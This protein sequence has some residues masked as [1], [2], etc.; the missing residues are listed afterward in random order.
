MPKLPKIAQKYPI[1]K[2]TQ[3]SNKFGGGGIITAMKTFA[4]LKG[5]II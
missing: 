4:F 5:R 3:N 1:E 2:G